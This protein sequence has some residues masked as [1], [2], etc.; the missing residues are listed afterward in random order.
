MKNKLI[1]FL[2]ALLIF[3]GCARRAVPELPENAEEIAGLTHLGRV[4]LS[5]ADQFAID[6]YEGGYSLIHIADGQRYLSVPEGGVVPEGL[7]PEIKVLR[8][9]L[10]NVYMAATAVMGL[11]DALGRND[12][13]RFSAVDAD[14]WYI[15]GPKAAMERG[16]IIYAGKYSLPDYELLASGGCSLSV[17]S[18]MIGHA[19]EVKEKLEELGITVLIDRSSYES[20]PLGR[21][22]WIKLYGELLGESD[23]AESLFDEQ[24]AYLAGLPEAGGEKKTVVCFYISGS[25]QIITRRSGDYV[26]KMI[27]LAGGESILD[28]PGADNALPTVAMEPEEFYVKAREADVIIYNGTVGGEMSSLAELTDKNPLL[29]DF[30][31]VQSGNVWCTRKSFFQQSLGLGA[32][33]ADFAAVFSGGA[34]DELP[35]LYRLKGGDGS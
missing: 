8:R 9:P 27:E 13:V 4:E 18:T 17:Q 1:I 31:A 14:G 24:A 19:P 3:S 29:A 5:F 28:E 2:A 20:H 11:F 6:R 10:K 15:D 35:C 22:E 26:S 16:D 30:R 21:S 34:E 33:I 32:V 23:L 12:A 25:G 7:D